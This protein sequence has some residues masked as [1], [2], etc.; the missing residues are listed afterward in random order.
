[1]KRTDKPGLGQGLERD[2]EYYSG[3]RFKVQ[4]LVGLTSEPLNPVLVNREPDNLNS[5][6][7]RMKF[8]FQ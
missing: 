7:L 3:S 1:M 5:Y 4:R 8:V 6:L 2:E